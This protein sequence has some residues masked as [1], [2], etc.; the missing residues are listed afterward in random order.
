MAV[1]LYY[2]LVNPPTEVVHQALLYWDGIASVVPTDPEVCDAAVGQP[3]KELEQRQLYTPVTHTQN[4]VGGLYPPNSSMRIARARPY[5]SA[6]LAEEL[7]SLAAS[8]EPPRPSWPP[9]AFLHPTKAN[10]WLERQ[11]LQ[12]GLAETWASRPLGTGRR[13]AVAREVQELVVGV[14][15]REIAQ[16]ATERRLFP[17]TDRVEAQRLALRPAA[18]G[19][20]L[21]WEIEL[22]KLLPAPAAETTLAEVLAFREKYTD[23]RLRLMRALHRLLG[24]LRRDYEHPADIFAQLR[25]KL[26]EALTDYRSAARDSRIVWVHR[27]VTVTMGLAAAAAGSLLLPSLDWL[28][29]VVGG[30]TL[31]VA[32]REIRPVVQRRLEHDFSYLHRVHTSLP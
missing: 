2:P 10:G 27:S 24:D 23:E 18:D 30:V 3:L 7:E 4:I 6:V 13:L 16:L 15:A 26:D 29:G 20:A 22:G 12:L 28:L 25:V 32:T 17:Y 8:A 1:L 14:L 5:V 21:A 11:L 9:D 31:N 19:Q